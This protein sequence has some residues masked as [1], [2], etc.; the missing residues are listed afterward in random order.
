ML[1]KALST[2]DAKET[3]FIYSRV[4]T[5]FLPFRYSVQYI[6]DSSIQDHVR[7]TNIR[8]APAPAK[9]LE[10]AS[11]MGLPEGWECKTNGKNKYIFTSPTGLI[12][13]TKRAAINYIRETLADDDDPPW[14]TSNHE[15]LQRRVKVV[16]THPLSGRRSIR[17]EQLGYVVG[18]ISATDCDR[19]GNPGYTSEITNE[20]AALFHVVFD[21]ARGHPHFKYLVE[22]QDMEEVE[23]RKCLVDD[24][25]PPSKK[26]KQSM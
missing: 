23:V 10:L 18:W 21:E 15:L 7:E 25:G 17:I 8:M 5:N 16:N 14:R 20:P 3:L 4:L 1:L 11:S 9:A 13:R 6:V 19:L 22:S 24:S 26:A 2:F 12:F